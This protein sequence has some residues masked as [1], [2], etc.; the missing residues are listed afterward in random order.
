MEAR[1]FGMRGGKSAITLAVIADIA[2]HSYGFVVDSV[3]DITQAPEG[4][5]PI[6]GR[7][8]PAW[9]PYAA[10]LVEHD[11]YSHLLL[12]LADFVAAP[13]ATLAA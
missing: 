12:S 6:R 10:G 1:I 5:Q 8:D 2:A 4:I 7:I 13:C 9:T 11:G 3:S